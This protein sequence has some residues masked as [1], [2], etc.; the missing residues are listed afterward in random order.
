M[1][2]DKKEEFKIGNPEQNN[3]MRGDREL[4]RPVQIS[5]YIVVQ[6]DFPLFL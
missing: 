1:P 2:F 6:V 4:D 5:S 3:E